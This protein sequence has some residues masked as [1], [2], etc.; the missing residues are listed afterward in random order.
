MT[1]PLSLNLRWARSLALA[2]KLF[3]FSTLWGSKG[4]TEAGAFQ[5]CGGRGESQRFPQLLILGDGERKCAM[6]NVPGAERIHGVDR[7]GRRLLQIALL[8]EP[9][10]ALGS[11]GAGQERRRQPGKLFQRLAVIGDVGGLL[12]RLAREHQMR[13]RGEQPF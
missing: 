3:N 2:Q 11:A 1:S 13:G 4:T 6:E 8:V 5:G 12:Q 10:R 7:E 9:D